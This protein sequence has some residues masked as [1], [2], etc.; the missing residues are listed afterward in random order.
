MR[1]TKESVQ[2]LRDCEASNP[3]IRRGNASIRQSQ[4][5]VSDVM[6]QFANSDTMET[7]ISEVQNYF[8]QKLIKGEYEGSNFNDS[9]FTATIDGLYNFIIWVGNSEKFCRTWNAIGNFFMV[10]PD[11]TEYESIE[12]FKS[13]SRIMSENSKRI[14]AEKIE[15]LESE[16]NKLKGGS[17]D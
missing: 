7:K 6:V 8:K 11:F 15:K 14:T 5:H 9:Y 16:L 13:A 2:F 1:T 12:T 3:E 10:L 17:N 4:L